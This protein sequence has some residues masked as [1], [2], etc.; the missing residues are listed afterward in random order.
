VAF[1]L[2]DISFIDKTHDIVDAIKS[3][4]VDL[5]ASTK[6]E[7]AKAA[8]EAREHLLSLRICK[9]AAGGRSQRCAQGSQTGRPGAKRQFGQAHRNHGYLP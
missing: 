5:M 4:L 6:E 3:Q 2:A 1:A 8:S 7:A 9:R